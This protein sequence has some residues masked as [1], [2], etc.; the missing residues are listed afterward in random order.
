MKPLLL[1][2][3]V[4][5][6]AITA[7]C[8]HF[9]NGDDDTAPS[10]RLA[11]CRVKPVQQVTLAVNESGVLDMI[12]QEGDQVMAGQCIVRLQDDLARAALA[13]A[14][15]EA[16]N[17]VDIR[18]SEVASDVAKLEHEQSIKVNETV[19]GSITL[20]E[21]R[22]RQLELDQSILRIELARF[23]QSVASLKRDQAVAQLK[24]FRVVAPFTGTV[25]KVS[26]HEGEAVRQGDPVL[27]LVNTRR[28]RVEGYLDAAQRR[29]VKPGTPVQVAPEARRD[30]AV[31]GQAVGKIVF[32][33][34]VVQAVTQQVRVWADVDNADELLLPGQTAVM[35]I[36]PQAQPVASISR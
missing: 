15:K 25:H 12:V 11:G 28:V 33:D 16:S 10:I 18:Y 34:T 8:N 36:V 27:E 21:L 26:K 1:R 9:A 19:K 23:N 30:E 4:S 32:V 24:A 13:V 31:P 5:A 2:L 14:E 6:I 7:T 35:K 3:F 20:I 29:L 22:R 17:D